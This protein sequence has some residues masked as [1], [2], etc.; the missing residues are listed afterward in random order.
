MLHPDQGG[1]LEPAWAE[2][3]SFSLTDSFRFNA[4]QLV[5]PGNAV[6]ETVPLCEKGLPNGECGITDL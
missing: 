1:R 3:A 4:F 2:L 6:L 5:G